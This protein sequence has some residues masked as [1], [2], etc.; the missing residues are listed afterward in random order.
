MRRIGGG[1]F[2]CQVAKDIVDA[3]GDGELSTS[4]IAKGLPQYSYRE[5]KRAVAK[6]NG[7]AISPAYARKGTNF[8]RV[9]K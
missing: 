1:Q 3:I 9:I 8:Y 7:L 4:E 5:V 2:Y 6:L